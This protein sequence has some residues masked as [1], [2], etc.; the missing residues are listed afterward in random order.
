ME[1]EYLKDIRRNAGSDGTKVKVKET[2]VIIGD[3]QAYATAK[4]IEVSSSFI[5]TDKMERSDIFVW[6]VG[7]SPTV[8]L[9]ITLLAKVFAYYNRRRASICDSQ[10]DDRFERRPNRE[11][12]GVSQRAKGNEINKF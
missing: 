9:A 4:E 7:R 5:S 3:A 10:R 2:E 12:C 1:D 11:I 6:S 8:R